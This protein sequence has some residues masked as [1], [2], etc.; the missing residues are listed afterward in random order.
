MRR[1][2]LEIGCL[3]TVIEITGMPTPG[4]AGRIAQEIAWPPDLRG[5]EDGAEKQYKD[6]N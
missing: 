2:V 1:I 4:I 5:R 3:P 6:E